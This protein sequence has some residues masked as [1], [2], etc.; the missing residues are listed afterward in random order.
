[1]GET[2]RRIRSLEVRIDE[3]RD[4]LERLE[5]QKNIRDMRDRVRRRR[6]RRRSR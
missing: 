5:L 6:P 4:E 2:R 1:M 3:K